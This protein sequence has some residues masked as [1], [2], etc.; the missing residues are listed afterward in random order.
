MWHA[1]RPF[2]RAMEGW[3]TGQAESSP[4]VRLNVLHHPAL[5]ASRLPRLCRH[6]L[7]P[8]PF[9]PP[10]PCANERSSTSRQRLSTARTS[11]V[12]PTCRAWL[13]LTLT[14]TPSAIHLQLSPPRPPRELHNLRTLATRA[15]A[16]VQ[17]AKVLPHGPLHPL[18]QLSP[19]VGRV[20]SLPAT[21]LSPPSMI[22]H[23][24]LLLLPSSLTPSLSPPS[25]MPPRTT[26]LVL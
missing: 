6:P 2:A 13:D 21:L 17:K 24:A 16:R 15:S 3:C 7:P 4:T 5:R 22:S 25:T 12:S 8:S 20:L 11:A 26:P 10:P 14:T 23:P 9:S 19:Q 1:T 18:P